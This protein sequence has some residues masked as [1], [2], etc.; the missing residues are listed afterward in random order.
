MPRKNLRVRDIAT[1]A[2]LELDEVLVGL[3]DAGIEGPESGDSQI[4]AGQEARARRL[5]SLADGKDE[6]RVEYWLE[7]TGKDRVE[8]TAW[9]AERGVLVGPATRRLPKN[10][11]RRLRRAIAPE[12]HVRRSEPAAGVTAERAVPDFAWRTIGSTAAVSGLTFEEVKAIHEHL[13][14]E[15]AASSDPIEPAGVRDENLLHSAVNRPFTSLGPTAKYPSVEMASAALFH[16][17]VL[18]HAFFNGNKRTALV[19][20]IVFLDRNERVL[21]ASER[22]LFR[23]TLRVAQHSIVPTGADMLADREVLEIAQ[24]VRQNS[25]VVDRR[26]YVMKWRK[27]KQRLR[28]SGCDMETAQVGNRLNV[29]R[30]EVAPRRGIMGRRISTTLQLRTQVACAGN[31]TDADRD[32]IRKIRK[33]LHLDEEHGVDSSSFYRGELVDSFITEHRRILY[34]LARL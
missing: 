15:F 12:A 29:W 27:L 3:W 5:F 25:R 10:G 6:S 19:S 32:T 24:W 1:E 20:L 30:S 16:S 9:A 26:E 22:E 2:S 17:L 18:N 33:D 21:A 8:F 13:E 23:F 14:R 4:P 11:A 7:L 28:E 34:K 31:G